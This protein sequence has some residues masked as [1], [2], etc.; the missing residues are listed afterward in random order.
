MIHLRSFARISS[1]FILLSSGFLSGAILTTSAEAAIPQSLSLVARDNL[2]ANGVQTYSLS[3]MVLPS[4]ERAKSITS[5]AGQAFEFVA[6]PIVAQASLGTFTTAEEMIDA[7]LGDWTYQVAAPADPL[8]IETYR[9]SISPLT[10]SD[11]TIERPTILQPV[12]GTL[13]RGP[14]EF[15]WDPPSE[16]YGSG[17]TAVGVE[18]TLVRPGLL[19]VT[20]IFNPQFPPRM[21]TISFSTST[22]Q[23]LSDYVSS[24]IPP[25]NAQFDPSVS[26]AFSRR[27]EVK[28]F[29]LPI[30]EPASLTAAFRCGT[31]TCRSS[32]LRVL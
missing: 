32:R 19:R 3:A 18:R 30:P 14:I 15:E 5:P 25:D 23:N 28:V 2:D 26:L 17:A 6:S 9:F 1:V 24:I 29:A 4:A 31:C 27:I 21:G 8:V 16:S 11:L 12:N 22:G 10:S 7:L 20:P 13:V